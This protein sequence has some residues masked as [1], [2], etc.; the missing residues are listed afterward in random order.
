VTGSG[1]AW[2]ADVGARNAH[3][4]ATECRTARPMHVL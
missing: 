1:T 2:R 4:L 3:W